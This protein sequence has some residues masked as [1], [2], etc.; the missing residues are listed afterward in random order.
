MVRSLQFRGIAFDV[1][2]EVTQVAQGEMP[3]LLNVRV[4]ENNVLQGKRGGK[5]TG[6]RVSF[7]ARNAQTQHRIQFTSEAFVA[8]LMH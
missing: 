6:R 4:F 3:A 5:N 2:Y 8:T 1:H 7:Q